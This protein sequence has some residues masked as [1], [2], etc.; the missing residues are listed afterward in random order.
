MIS[1]A[2]GDFQARWIGCA[3]AF[4]SDPKFRAALPPKYWFFADIHA[5]QLIWPTKPQWV[6][7]AS[8]GRGKRP[9]KLIP[10]PAPVPVAAVAQDPALPW[11]TIVL[12]EGAKGPILAKVKRCRVIEYRDGQPGDEL[13]LYIR[14]YENRRIKYAA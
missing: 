14:Q 1:Q 8:K 5:D 13:W 2:A 4:G 9:Q 6:L 7:P 12:A 10:S 11:E 3:S